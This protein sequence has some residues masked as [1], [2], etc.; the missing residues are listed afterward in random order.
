MKSSEIFF[1]GNMLLLKDKIVSIIG[2]GNQGRAQGTVL[3]DNGVNV[4]VLPSKRRLC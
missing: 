2:Y 4:I 1:D 3:K